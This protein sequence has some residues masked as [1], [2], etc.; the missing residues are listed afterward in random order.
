M[1]PPVAPVQITRAAQQVVDTV[2]HL[3]GEPLR[4]D[5]PMLGLTFDPPPPGAFG[6]PIGMSVMPS[7]LYF[8]ER[9][10]VCMLNDIPQQIAADLNLNTIFFP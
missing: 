4:E 9:P 7:I 1:L 5:G 2:E 6:A 8:N 3:I 10:N